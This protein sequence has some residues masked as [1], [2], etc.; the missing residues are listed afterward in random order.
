MKWISLLAIAFAVSA[1]GVGTTFKSLP[2]NGKFT[3]AIDAPIEPVPLT[4]TTP[5][6]PIEKPLSV[7]LKFSGHDWSELNFTDYGIKEYEFSH[8]PS[9][10]TNAPSQWKEQAISYSQY[11]AFSVDHF[12]DNLLNG[13]HVLTGSNTLCP[14]YKNMSRGQRIEFWVHFI[15]AV[16]K[17]ESGYKPNTRYHES[18][19][20]YKDSV[21]GENVY[22]EGLLQLSYQDGKSYKECA[23][24]FNWNE[25]KLLS[26]TSL[27]KTIFD[28]MRN[29]YC[30]VRIMNRIIK[31][32]KTLI[33]DSGNYWAVLRPTSKYGKTA[34]ITSMVQARTPN[35]F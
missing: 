23:G 13:P 17:F 7:V 10:E 12:G 31:S 3:Q 21:T 30:G 4:P 20:N 6:Q 15:S 11:A 34:E 35:C 32:K 1:C 16:T 22:S 24:V 18:T 25:D 9:W 2:G 14:K 28:P 27:E 8:L 29:L 33:F 19:F 5:V 26:R